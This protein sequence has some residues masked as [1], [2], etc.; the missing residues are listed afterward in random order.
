M[1]KYAKDFICARLCHLTADTSAAISGAS[2]FCVLD[3]SMTLTMKD[4]V[5]R[6]NKE[7]V[8]YIEP[9]MTFSIHIKTPVLLLGAIFHPCFLLEYLGFKW[10]HISCNS[11]TAPHKDYKQI[12]S[13]LA[14]LT[15]LPSDTDRII[16]N[17]TYAKSFEFLHVLEKHYIEPITEIDPDTADASIFSLKYFLNEHYADNL[18]LSDVAEAFNYTPPYLSSLIKKKLHM[19]FQEYMTSCRLEA[20][21]LYT[22]YTHYSSQKIYVTCGF[23]NQSSFLQAFEKKYGCS[24]DTWRLEHVIAPMAFPESFDIITSTSLSRDYLFNYINYEAYNNSTKGIHSTEE[25]VIIEADLDISSPVDFHSAEMVNLGSASDF[26]KPSF[27]NHI[28]KFQERKHIRYGRFS[29]LLLVIS[30]FYVHDRLFYDFSRAFQIFDF[31]RSIHMLPLIEL[32][33]KPFHIYKLDETEFFD[34]D[35]YNNDASYDA[36]T[37]QVLPELLNACIARY[38]F[39]EVSTWK[40]ELWRRYSPSMEF[41]EP[42][43]DYVDRFSKVASILKE[44]I[45]A[46]QIGGPGFNMFLPPNVFKEVILAFKD[47]IYTPDFYS[48]YYFP[49]SGKNFITPPRTDKKVEYHISESVHDMAQKTSTVREL[50]D[51]AGLKHTPLYITEYSAFISEGNTLNDSAYP[52]LFIIY[53]ALNNYLSAQACAYW[54]ISDISLEYHNPASLFFGGNGLIS[55]D[56]IFK[57]SCFAFTLLEMLG[58]QLVVQNDHYVIT[59]TEDGTIQILLY[60]IG[61][62][63][64]EFARAPSEHDLLIYPYSP[65][66]RQLPLNFTIELNHMHPGYHLIKEYRLSM[67]YGSIINSWKNL[68]YSNDLDPLDFEYIVSNSC[69]YRSSK[70]ELIDEHYT[71]HAVLNPN[72]VV[73]FICR[74]YYHPFT[75]DILDNGGN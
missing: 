28:T 35:I 34:Y 38:G 59:R 71:L 67:E 14:P 65:F 75:Q 1:P 60:Y 45:P 10:K 8:I 63:D 26:D 37:E 29:D 49:Y 57:P 15:F 66:T 32:G 44:K 36:H 40:F 25:E 53:Q 47:Q 33:N 22:H 42:A 52:A 16:S 58:D 64:S 46:I 11:T 7:D 68:G 13:H 54:L 30:T 20:A 50:L 21:F 2:F 51:T 3:G 18:S 61:Q 31:L 43:K 48:A 39:D 17:Y 56:G 69:P 9:D 74:P 5:F 72:E 19:T 55:R 23:S 24:P 70:K 4:Q 12:I 27:R 62:L 6:L 41:I 73:M